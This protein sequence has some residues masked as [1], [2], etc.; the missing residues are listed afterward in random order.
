MDEGQGSVAQQEVAQRPITIRAIGRVSL[1]AL[2]AAVLGGGIWGW[3]VNLTNYEIGYVAWGLGAL[4]GFTVIR[5]A[6]GQRGVPFQLIAVMS[7]LI[8]IGIGKYLSFIPGLKAWVTQDYGAEVAASISALSLE[9]LRLFFLN[10]DKA[11][12]PY[13]ILWVG[14]AVFTAWGITRG[15]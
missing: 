10:L 3:V 13:D 2:L 14:L 7:G 8:G 4:C 11:L 1:G 9:T 15:S 12:S 6:Q 5:C